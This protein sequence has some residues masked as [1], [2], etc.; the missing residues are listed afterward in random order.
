MKKT[1]VLICIFTIILLTGC[2]NT[3]DDTKTLNCTKDISTNGISMIQDA[4]V[5]FKNNKIDD[6]GST[7]LVTLPDSYKPYM[8]TFI[9]S[10]DSAYAK[11]YEGNNHVKVTTTKKSDSEI[12]IDISFDYKNMTS[13]EKVNANFIGSEDYE[14]N[15]ADLEKRGYTCK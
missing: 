3:L 5:K 6:I 9:N 13:D 8:S 11:Q 12:L 2:N 4:F 1:I 14:I 15:K 7:I 10:F